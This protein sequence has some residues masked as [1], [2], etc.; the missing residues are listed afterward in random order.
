[1]LLA[2]QGLSND[3]TAAMLGGEGEQGDKTDA[4]PERKGMKRGKGKS[5]GEVTGGKCYR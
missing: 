4:A 2:A 1:M 3:G 5:G